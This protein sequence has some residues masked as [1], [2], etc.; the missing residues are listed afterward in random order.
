MSIK[1]NG[2]ELNE[3]DYF[4]LANTLKSSAKSWRDL[5]KHSLI[6]EE[7]M[8]NKAIKLEEWSDFLM[9]EAQVLFDKYT[10]DDMLNPIRK[11]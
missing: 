9:K 2:K 5:A 3:W 1:L 6:N 7:M 4:L 10:D 11:P 8:L